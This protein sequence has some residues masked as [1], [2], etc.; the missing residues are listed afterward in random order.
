LIDGHAI[1]HRSFHAIPQPLTLST[2]GEDVRA[3]YGF[4]NALLRSISE[5]KPTHIIVTFDLP[6]PTFRHQL[7][8]QYKAHRK[9]TPPELKGQ[10]DIVKSLMV[11][12]EIPI[13]EMPGFEADDLLGTLSN[14]SEQLK[15]ETL[16]LTGDSDTLQLVTPYVKV[17]MNS[18]TQK[19]TI[20][21]I[22]AVE[23]RYEGLGPQHVAQIKALQGDVSD[24][25]PGIPGIGIKTAISLLTKFSS[26]NG[27]YENINS[28]PKG[29]IKNNLVEY[30]TLAYSSLELTEIVTDVPIKLDLHAAEFGN[31]DRNN[32]IDLLTKLE[33]HSIINR[34]PK[35]TDLNNFT[36]VNSPDIAKESLD[37][38]IVRNTNDLN[39]LLVSLNTSEGFSFDTETTS[40]NPMETKIVG[41]SFSI[42]SNSGWYIPIGHNQGEQLQ[43]E[44][45]INALTPIMNNSNISKRAHNA[46]FDITVLNNFG[47]N[48]VGLD[49]DTM[50][51]AHIL[52]RRNIGL[53][54]LVLENFGVEMVKI[55][56]LIGS[57]RKRITMAEVDIDNAASYSIADADYTQRLYKKLKAELID[58]KIYSLLSEVEVPL[59]NVLVKMQSNGI[60]LNTDLLNSMSDI[61]GSQLSNIEQS[62]FELIDNK[63]NLNS[64]KQLSDLLFN[65]LKLPPTRKIKSGFSTDAQALDDLKLS[66]EYGNAP[67][68]DYRSYEILNLILENREISK[69]KSTYVDS[70]P[71]LINKNTNKLHTSYKQTGTSTGRIS[72]NDPNVQNIP[73]RTELGRKVREAFIPKNG[74]NNVLLA[75]DYSQIE[76]RVLAHF[77][78]DSGLIAAFNNGE[79]IHSATAS[80]VYNV[81]LEKITIDMRRIA[82]VLNF[83]VIYGLSAHGIARQT[84]LNQKEG[85]RFIDIY[86]EKYPGILK[87]LDKIKEQC[88][89]SGFMETILGR[90]R[91]FPDV[92]SSN[93]RVRSQAE[94]AAI[95]MPIQ[96]TAADIIKIAMIQI[97]NKMSQLELDSLMILQVHDELIFEV[98]NY[99]TEQMESILNEI[100]PFSI[101]L[102]VPLQIEMKKGLSWGILQ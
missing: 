54:E 16:I 100:M 76:L 82:K 71:Q 85:K 18:G 80:L 40:L 17:V 47:I 38:K 70:L 39:Q 75:A 93:F 78:N 50:I 25:I 51:A 52:G 9:P 88:R 91:Y 73:V 8:N 72:S 69:I 58:K 84:D 24:N 74:T 44:I 96:G 20:Y 41:I 36:N 1:I 46:N 35:I 60:Y 55:E 95:N 29:K 26:I 98:P 101:P 32:V 83:G 57:G 64:P 68:A 48:I 14:Q 92:N 4:A 81:P 66:L 87:Y 3:V 12:F 97:Q 59:V 31:Y 11:A 5:L 90:R 42:N 6:K 53:K 13:Y 67:H 7:F 34:L 65:E 23:K 86:F 49:F 10:F 102:N 63:L 89:N 45:I 22:S 94:R 2:T 61:L 37:Y 27:V 99:E 77:S 19:Q 15:I 43:P 79:D 30:K 21:D 28:I 56:E 33:F 62:I